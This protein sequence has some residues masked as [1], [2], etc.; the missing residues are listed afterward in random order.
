MERHRSLENS[1]PLLA[2]LAEAAASSVGELGDLLEL[3]RTNSGL[4]AL[5]PQVDEQLWRS[6]YRSSSGYLRHL[7]SILEE[8]STVTARS[9]DEQ[10]ALR[11]IF[12]TMAS[13]IA[14][15]PESVARAIRMSLENAAE[16]IPDAA[17]TLPAIQFAVRVVI[18]CYAVYGLTPWH[19]Q[20][21]IRSESEKCEASIRRLVRLDRRASDLGVVRRWVTRS[22]EMA[23]FHAAKL[24]K[25]RRI[26]TAFD[27]P[28]SD[29]HWLKA[30]LG[31]LSAVSDLCHSRMKVPALR[32]L[33][34]DAGDSVP[35]N[36]QEYLV[37]TTND[38]LSREIRRKR[39]SFH[40][41]AK[42]DRSIVETVRA[43][44][45]QEP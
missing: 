3:R 24:Q 5:E 35:A 12:L 16:A 29:S 7:L 25:W 38:D 2:L 31:L 15:L 1:P 44:L 37:Q 41:P 22:P 20:R 30:T 39:R 23:E 6:F 4:F 40:L 18:P 19:L 34:A 17:M 10:V 42:P 28:K 26:P 11:L 9:L 27:R 13:A 33:L 32:Q 43:L 8:N 36:L 45:K 14:L 21:H